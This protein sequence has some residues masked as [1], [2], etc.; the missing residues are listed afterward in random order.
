MIRAGFVRPGAH[1]DLDPSASLRAGRAHPVAAFLTP[2]RISTYP[3][4]V[5][6]IMALTFGLNL[7]GSTGWR[8]ANGQLLFPDFILFYSTGTLFHAAPLSVY[9]FQQQLS[10]QRSLVAP[11]PMDGTGAFS[12]PPYVAALFEP[13]T[14]LSL[15]YAVFVWTLL[16]CAAIAGSIAL[17]QRIVRQ[18]PWNI[19]VP[20]TTVVAIALSFAPVLF[21][22]GAGQMHA[23]VLLGTL[24]VVVFV[25]EDK[26]WHAGAAAGLLAIKPQVALAFLI[27]FAAKRNLRA[28]LAAALA[29]GALNLLFI[30][31]AGLEVAVSL[32]RTYFEFTRALLMMPFTEGFPGFML[33]TPY[34]L[35]SGFVGPERQGAILMIANILAA[36]AVLWFL[37]DASRWRHSAEESTRLLLG[38]TLLLPSLITPYLMVYD[39]AP[40]MLSCLLSVPA[41]MPHVALGLGAMVY[42]GLL[43]DPS[44]SAAIGVPLGALIPIALWI[45]ASLATT[46]APSEWRHRGE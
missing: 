7:A 35:M 4:I 38:R 19:V 29:F 10:L 39:A 20:R 21:G 11:T 37:I 8:G 41:T 6:I 31:R 45:V 13:L 34:G 22:L 15:P 27:F 9:D 26:P 2:R 14:G 28:C 5:L 40:L 17:A 24:A 36:A 16:S 25:L 18:Q 1:G 12:H 42:V 44:I 43:I 33:L 46:S 23:F 30:S 32:Y 3:R